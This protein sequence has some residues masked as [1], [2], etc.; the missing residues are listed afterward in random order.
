MLTPSTHEYYIVLHRDWWLRIGFQGGT[1]GQHMSHLATLGTD[2]E[3]IGHLWLPCKQDIDVGSG[4]GTRR[5]AEGCTIVTCKHCTQ[6]ITKAQT[7]KTFM[8]MQK[9]SIVSIRRGQEELLS[10]KGISVP[11]Y[12]M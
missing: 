11:T 4:V 1:V 10:R 8:E 6:M 7:E 12:G 9:A 5:V 3:Y 2:I